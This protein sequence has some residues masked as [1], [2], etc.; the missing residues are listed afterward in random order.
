MGVVTSLLICIKSTEHGS[1]SRD[2]DAVV[3]SKAESLYLSL[4]S[5]PNARNIVPIATV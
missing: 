3:R 1:V 4:R 2:S 5:Q